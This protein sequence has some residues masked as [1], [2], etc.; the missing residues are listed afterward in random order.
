LVNLY[1]Q[2]VAVSSE[3]GISRWLMEGVIG[4]AHIARGE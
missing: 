2:N 1:P 3:P 4:R